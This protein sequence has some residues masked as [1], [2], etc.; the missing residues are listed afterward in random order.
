MAVMASQAAMAMPKI[1]ETGVMRKIRKPQIKN[2]TLIELITV[3]AIIVLIIGLV[4]GRVGKLPVFIT[5]DNQVNKVK[6][7]FVSARSRAQLQGKDFAV[8]YNADAKKFYIEE[9]TADSEEGKK[10]SNRTFCK[11]ADSIEVKTDDC[12]ASEIAFEFYQDGSAYGPTIY[13]QL[14]KHKTMLQVSS[15]SGAINVSDIENE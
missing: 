5:L 11:L 13:F 4:A 9:L 10:L 2:F 1:L 15:L 7:L 8:K 14:K 12:S 3:L 6:K